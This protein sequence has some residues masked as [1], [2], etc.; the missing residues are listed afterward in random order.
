MRDHSPKPR[1][2]RAK[3]WGVN[4]TL[5]LLSI[6][7]ILA[8]TGPNLR[9]IKLSAMLL[10]TGQVLLTISIVDFLWSYF[11]KEDELRIIEETTEKTAKDIEDRI[12]QMNQIQE[13]ALLAVNKE[14]RLADRSIEWGGKIVIAKVYIPEASSFR[15]VLEEP[16]KAGLI[17]KITI[18][19]V[20][21]RPGTPGW[22]IHKQRADL[23]GRTYQESFVNAEKSIKECCNLARFIK[24]E[25]SNPIE[26]S[27]F[28][29]DHQPTVSITQVNSDRAYLSFFFYGVRSLL[30]PQFLIDLTDKDADITQTYAAHLESLMEYANRNREGCHFDMA[31]MEEVQNLEDTQNLTDTLTKLREEARAT[32]AGSSGGSEPSPR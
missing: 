8:G 25:L 17:T 18:F 7:L 24:K 30:S 15:E 10:A 5:L 23:T 29:I 1:R 26:F 3:F 12:K 13:T 22:Q 6:V 2:L 31:N 11:L 16:L 28:L 14:L 9:S 27:V 32:T 20:D 4:G 19:L 21:N